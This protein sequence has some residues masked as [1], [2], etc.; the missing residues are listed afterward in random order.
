[1]V[2]KIFISLDSIMDT[3]LG[4]VAMFSE[5]AAEELLA[6]KK[7]HSRRNNN[8]ALILPMLN[9]KDINEIYENRDS[10]ILDY[11]AP[12]AIMDM[13]IE[14]VVSAKTPDNPIMANIKIE[15]D[16]NIWPYTLTDSAM[17][18]LKESVWGVLPADNVNIVNIPVNN[19]TPEFIGEYSTVIWHEWN[20]W[21]N[22]HLEGLTT[23]CMAGTNFYCPEIIV[24]MGNI[25]AMEDIPEEMP[26]ME[27]QFFLAEYLRLN[28]LPLELFSVAPIKSDS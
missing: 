8:W 16:I 23:R 1:M 6:S 5:K 21:G 19:M 22:K 7:Y 15:I 4:A 27:L 13:V 11:S 12:T 25:A 14:M 3:R 26:G 20:E 9:T 2:K 28:I 24:N 10:K 18:I 17:N